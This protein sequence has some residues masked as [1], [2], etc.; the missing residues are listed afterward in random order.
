MP[1]KKE[2]TVGDV[3][4]RSGLAVSTIHFYETKGLIR[5]QRN[6]GN[7]RRY[8][9]DVLRR[10]A[11]I[12]V[13]QLAG[14]PLREIKEALATIPHD[15]KVTE[16]HWSRLARLWR[17]N[18]DDRIDRLTGLRDTLEECIG[19]GCLSVKDCALMNEDDK[20]GR[21]GSGARILDPKT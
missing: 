20:L 14:I 15:G 5:S 18:L 13:A 7:H 10:L 1:V 21:Q 3:A 19:C 16:K 2:L 11:V 6:Q 4:A 17:A 12:N 8:Q 9:R